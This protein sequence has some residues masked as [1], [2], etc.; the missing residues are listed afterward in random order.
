MLAGRLGLAQ[1]G[2]PHADRHGLLWLGNAKLWVED[3]SIVFSTSG[4]GGLE[5]GTYRVPFQGISMLVLEPGTSVTHDVL[6]L[7]AR[8]GVVLAAVGEGGVR[9]YTAP[10]LSPDRSEVAR[11]QARTWADP[12]TRAQIARRMYAWRFQA[13]LPSHDLDIL[14]GIEGRRARETYKLV[15][16]RFGIAWKGRKYD[17]ADPA[18]GDLPNQ[19]LNHAAT[20]IYAA[21][22][23]ATAAVGAIPQLGFIHE[24][25]GVSFCLDIAD[26]YR[27]DVTLPLAF[28]A[29]KE[30]QRDP[31]LSVERYVR[32]LCVTEFRRSDLVASMIDRIKELFDVSDGH[33]DP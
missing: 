30:C 31:S 22:G 2:I 19:A 14:R 18:A 25:S 15:A 23:L 12:D 11:R 1:A 20:A 24:S 10:P 33:H 28:Q 9:H 8:H 4:C 6:R 21:A 29:A 27:D 16:Q 32:R 7:A 13:V 3:G 26:L 17:R 5:A